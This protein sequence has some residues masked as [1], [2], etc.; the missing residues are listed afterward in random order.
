MWG[1]TGALSP[2]LRVRLCQERA[3]PGGGA[4]MLGVALL[5]FPAPSRQAWDYS[6]CR[7]HQ[8]QVKWMV[9]VIGKSPNSGQPFAV[10]RY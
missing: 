1:P 9:T 3:Q 2:G 5:P 4:G 8:N 6:I 7:G 10:N